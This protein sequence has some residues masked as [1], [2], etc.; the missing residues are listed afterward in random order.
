VREDILRFGFGI[1]QDPGDVDRAVEV[2]ARV[3]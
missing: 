1:Y 2:C 3:L